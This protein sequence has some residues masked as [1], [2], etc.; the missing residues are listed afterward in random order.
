MFDSEDKGWV[1]NKLDHSLNR[2]KNRI[3]DN[4][5]SCRY[6]DQFVLQNGIKLIIEK[7]FKIKFSIPKI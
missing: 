7:T 5:F 3:G 4:H 6:F 2:N 1:D